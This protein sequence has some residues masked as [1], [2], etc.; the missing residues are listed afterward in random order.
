[1]PLQ[2]PESHTASGWMTRADELHRELEQVTRERDALKALLLEVE[3]GDDGTC[4]PCCR[5]LKSPMD[6]EERWYLF[7][8]NEGRIGHAPD[9]RLKAALEG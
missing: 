1:M 9:C 5:A 4:C 2:N 8:M 7:S 6:P 3:W